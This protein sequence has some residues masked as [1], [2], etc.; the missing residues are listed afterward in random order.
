MAAGDG[1]ANDNDKMGSL[2]PP[3][4]WNPIAVSLGTRAL[5]TLDKM[6]AWLGPN[7]KPTPAGASELDLHS[8]QQPP[9]CFLSYPLSRRGDFISRGSSS[10]LWEVPLSSE[11]DRGKSQGA[12]LRYLILRICS[13]ESSFHQI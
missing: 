8:A 10:C 5:L 7:H 9:C 2:T 3:I 12:T 1:S 6:V 4:T 13:S 11:A